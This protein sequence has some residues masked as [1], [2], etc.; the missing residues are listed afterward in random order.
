MKSYRSHKVVQAAKIEKMAD[1][2]AENRWAWEVE[3]GEILQMTPEWLTSRVGGGVITD[4]EELHRKA[5][6][7]YFVQYEDGYTS[8]SPAEAFESGYTEI[9]EPFTDSLGVPITAELEEELERRFIYHPPS[10]PA[11]VAAHEYVSQRTCYLAKLLSRLIP[12]SRGLSLAITKL[13]E[14]RMWANQ[15]IATG[16]RVLITKCDEEGEPIPVDSGPP[17]GDQS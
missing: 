16:Q 12:S 17:V 9:P 15:A 4:H 7:G 2:D 8:W 5:I 3:G 6:G 14:V 10:S 13:E 11:I 1:A